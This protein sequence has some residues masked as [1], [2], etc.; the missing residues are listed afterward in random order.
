MQKKT[1]KAL[2]IIE[3]LVVIVIIGIFSVV[4]YPNISKWITDRDVKKEVY[5]T[6]N[7]IK[8]MK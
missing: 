8:E 3:L 5:E 1:T 2:T 7:Y 4:A 6:I